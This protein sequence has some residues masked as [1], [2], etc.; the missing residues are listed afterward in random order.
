MDEHLLNPE[1]EGYFDW[2]EEVLPRHEAKKKVH[3]PR[4]LTK[5]ERKS[6]ARFAYQQQLHVERV[7]GP[8]AVDYWWMHA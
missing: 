2:E 5:Q 3:W 7:G 4:K 1:D 6:H 8:G